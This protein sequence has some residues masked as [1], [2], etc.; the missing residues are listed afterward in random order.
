MKK[1]FNKQ[2]LFISINTASVC[3]LFLVLY[4]R[5]D[6]VEFT[7]TLSY[8]V[9][10]PINDLEVYDF[11]KNLE[12]PNRV[13][14]RLKDNVQMG[15]QQKIILEIIFY[16][17]KSDDAFIEKLKNEFKFYFQLKLVTKDTLTEK[18]LPQVIYDAEAAVF[19]VQNSNGSQAKTP[20]FITLTS[21]SVTSEGLKVF[22][23]SKIENS[24]MVVITDK[25][26]IL[27]H[28]KKSKYSIEKDIN[29]LSIK[30]GEQYLYF[31]I[32]EIQ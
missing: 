25:L 7:Q 26:R 22:N 19:I 23:S 31:E 1:F 29:L 4:L 13:K 24:E 16:D 2:F 3:I 11:L 9:S 20:A 30:L 12:K 15:N 14:I 18:K 10:T 32:L 5:K 8:L 6:S 28:P 17:K 21:T 27:T